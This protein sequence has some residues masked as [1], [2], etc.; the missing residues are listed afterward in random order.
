MIDAEG[1]TL[2]SVL[3]LGGASTLAR[4]MALCFAARGYAVALAGRDTAELNVIA[5]DIHTRHARPVFVLPFDALDGDGHAGF[6]EKCRETLGEMPEGVVACFGLLPDQA[7]A[8]RDAALARRCLD[9]NYAGAVSVLE[10]FAAEFEQRRRGFIAGV[11]SVAGDRGRK[12][13][14]HY[15]AAKAAFTVYLQG[16]RNRLHGAGVTVTTIKPGFLDTKMTYGL[17]MPRRLVTAPDK[18]ARLA[19]NAILKGRSVA[20]VPEYWRVIMAVIQHIPEVVFK[21]MSI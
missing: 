12:G 6:A 1:R 14:Y 21:R 16:L 3:L 13:N 17:D 11:S 10:R 5:G 2:P 7:E 20:Y 8:Q 19:V 18:A 15:G 4:E 9:T